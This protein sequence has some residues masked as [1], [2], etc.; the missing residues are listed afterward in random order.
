MLQ[1]CVLVQSVLSPSLPLPPLTNNPKG[2]VKEQLITLELL[3]W[4]SNK[5]NKIICSDNKNYH[6]QDKRRIKK[7]ISICFP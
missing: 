3:A 7:L 1:H 2:R 4:R 6:Q 5:S